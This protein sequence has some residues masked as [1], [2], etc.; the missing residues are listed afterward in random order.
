MNQKTKTIVGIGLLTAIIIVLQ[1]VASTVR[2]GIFN[3]TLVL[4]PLIVGAALYGWYAGAWLGFVFG[5]VVLFTD[6]AV[7][8]AISVPGTIITVLAKGILAGVVAALVYLALQKKN[9][10]LAIVVAA[11]ATP[12]T[13]TG[14]FLVGCR[15]FF[16]DTIKGWASA[17]G[18]ENVGAYLI[19]GLVGMNFIVEM[20]INLLLSTATLRIVNI[21]K[22]EIK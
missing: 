11:I 5:M 19:F 8:M 17:S 6:T 10:Y 9:R 15:L 3:I 1:L 4:T 18:F 13:N 14:I 2:L 20:I 7:F 12:I 21:G 22:K 16:F